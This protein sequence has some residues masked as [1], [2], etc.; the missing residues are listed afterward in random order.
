MDAP[1]DER[2]SY[3]S[4]CETADGK[5]DELTMRVRVVLLLGQPTAYLSRHYQHPLV[6]D[7]LAERIVQM[8]LN[9]HAKLKS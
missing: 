1:G 2:K 9:L 6:Y 5:A 4:A 3:Q 7:M 8:K